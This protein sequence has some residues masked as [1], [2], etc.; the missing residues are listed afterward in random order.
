MSVSVYERVYSISYQQALRCLMRAH[1]RE[2][3]L[4]MAE[5][6]DGADIAA[7]L[8]A[9]EAGDIEQAKRAARRI[10]A[11]W[12]EDQAD[13]VAHEEAM[14]ASERRMVLES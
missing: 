4:S 13:M 12:A 7:V 3:Y 1:A 5:A 6:A 11:A 8:E 14:A 2:D 9:V 10:R